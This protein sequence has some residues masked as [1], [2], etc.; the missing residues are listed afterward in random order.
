MCKQMSYI[1]GKVWTWLNINT[2]IISKYTQRYFLNS[3]DLLLYA[4]VTALFTGMPF[5]EV[6]ANQWIVTSEVRQDIFSSFAP[7]DLKMAYYVEISW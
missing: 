4:N 3:Q 7:L 6:S 1:D 5:L 2:G